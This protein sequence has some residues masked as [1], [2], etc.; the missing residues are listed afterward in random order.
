M[1]NRR[2]MVSG[3]IGYS[4]FAALP[5]SGCAL[6][7]EEPQVWEGEALGAPARI[8]LYGLSA[9]EA[10][11]AFTRVNHRI[12]RLEHSFSL[13][14]PDS[15]ISRL[16]RDGQLAH[17]S[18]E[19]RLLLTKAKQVSVITNG[20]FDITVQVLWQA[21]Q[22]IRRQS[23][24]SR[25]REVLWQQVRE[26]V[27]YDK[28]LIE[29]KKVR[30]AVPDMAITLN[31]IAQGY[32]T[33]EVAKTLSGLGKN[34]SGLVNIGEFQAFGGRTF[35]VAIEDPQNPLDIVGEVEL[36]N[37][38]LATSSAL[39]GYLGLQLSHIF[40]PQGVDQ[41][42]QFISASVVHPSATIAD[43]L[44]TV[45]TL[46]DESAVRKIAKAQGVQQVVLKSA[47][48]QLMRF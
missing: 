39:G 31:G 2:Q 46:L 38:G 5:L 13:Y 29:G 24:D 16:N 47:D 14:C 18:K 36:K 30:L 28:I 41:T 7:Q 1:L 17:A 34:I 22:T 19:F 33:E 6:H 4:G 43:A 26:L 12:D 15:E 20:A 21:A 45:F 48:G 32:I 10:A 8:A 23:L 44:A 37:A 3:A 11:F 27:G 25:A 35:H 40:R 9:E 42:P